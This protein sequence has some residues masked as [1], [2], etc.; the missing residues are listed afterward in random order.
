MIEIIMLSTT[1]CP[2]CI[3]MERAIESEMQEVGGI[4]YGNNISYKKIDV[5]DLPAYGITRKVLLMQVIPLTFSAVGKQ[6]TKVF[7]IEG[8][9]GKKFK[10]EIKRILGGS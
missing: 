9:P 3:R 4:F 6:I 10:S 5:N 7:P 8:Y 2:A 1:N